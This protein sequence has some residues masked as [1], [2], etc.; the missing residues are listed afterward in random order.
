M[1]QLYGKLSAEDNAVIIEGE[2]MYNR[3]HDSEH[4]NF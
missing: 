3:H 1:N 2:T 4:K